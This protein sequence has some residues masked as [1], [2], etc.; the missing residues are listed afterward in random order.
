MK[1]YEIHAVFTPE[2]AE[3]ASELAGL[4]IHLDADIC[5]GC[6]AACGATPDGFLPFGVVLYDEDMEKYHY[7]CVRCLIPLTQ[8]K[9]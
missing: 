2:D 1:S 8:P 6:G 4:P 7:L 3:R 9:D 5:A